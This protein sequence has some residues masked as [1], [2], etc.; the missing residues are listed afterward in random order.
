MAPRR[1]RCAA[2]LI[3]ATLSV[4][5]AWSAAARTPHLGATTA[6]ATAART[7]HLGA[8]TAAH[9]RLATPQ[10]ACCSLQ[11]Y[12]QMA[13]PVLPSAVVA[14]C[15]LTRLRCPPRLCSSPWLRLFVRTL[16][17]RLAELQTETLDRR[18]ARVRPACFFTVN[19][20]RRC[21][22]RLAGPCMQSF[23]VPLQ[24]AGEVQTRCIGLQTEISSI[25]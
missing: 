24:R 14:A 13:H 1:S 21:G 23:T 2:M 12:A 15:M 3:L 8:T 22:V 9:Q 18:R 17:R 11:I 10:S 7:P 6:W 19:A 20:T 5:E 25:A 16:T 4:T